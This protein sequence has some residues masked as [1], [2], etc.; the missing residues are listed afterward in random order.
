MK[1]RSLWLET[2]PPEFPALRGS[3]EVDTLIVGGGITGLTTAY[4]LLRAGKRV[5]VVEQ[6]TIGG[7]DTGHTTAHVTFVTDSRLGDLV[8][9]VGE[10][11]ARALWEAGSL[12]M[13]E[14]EGICHDL[15]ISCDL[16]RVPGYLFAAADRDAGRER[17]SLAEDA[18][19]A[20]E[21][22]FNAE[23]IPE[24]PVFRR[25]AIHFP[26]QL[27]FH[28]IK[29][30]NALAAAVAE[31]GHLF[32][33]TSGSEVDADK[34]ELRTENGVIHYNSLV[35][36]THVPIQGE[37]GTFSAA[38]FQTKLAGYSSYAIEAGVDPADEGLFWD[39]ADPYLYAR[40][41]RRREGG[42]VI[43]GGEDHKTGT[44]PDTEACYERLTA[45]LKRWFPSAKVRHRWSGQVWE[46]PDGLPYIGETVAGQYLATGFAGNGMTLGT[47][48]AMLIRDLIEGRAGTRSEAFA[49]SRKSLRGVIDYVRENADFPAHFVRDHLRPVDGKG[50]AKRP[51]RGTGE[52]VKIDG[53]KQAV[54]V[55]PHGKRTVLSPICPHLGCVVQWNDAEQTWDCPCHGSRF[56]ATGELL[57]GPAESGLSK[58]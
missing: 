41:D 54:Y 37:R 39:T 18:R 55:N 31:G 52:L 46:T 56:A 49:P 45:A 26:N 21:F 13:A 25:P 23:L 48:G 22:G 27:K 24:A 14:I 10:E 43:L 42:S 16:R 51:K 47:F 36:A 28:P 33:G 19:L 32:A 15:A 40:I 53:R 29:Y 30:L 11:R 1:S 34:H 4:L 57:G 44:E 38:L 2:V 9:R 7:G 3:L 8:K 12:A 6:N 58:A 50:S 20:V 5:A 17:E 35:A